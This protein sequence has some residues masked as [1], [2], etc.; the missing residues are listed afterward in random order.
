MIIERVELRHV[1]PFT[2]TVVIGP[3]GPGLNVLSANNEAGKSTI[4]KAATRALFDRHICKSEEIKGLQ[5][6]GS[7]L[8]PAITV[9][10][11]HSGQRYRVEKV[12]L[13]SPRSQVSQ[14][15]GT[16][17]Q[18]KAEGDGA[19]TLLQQILPIWSF[20]PPARTA[21]I[22]PAAEPPNRNT[23]GCSS[24]SGLGR[25]NPPLGRTGRGK[26]G[27]WFTHG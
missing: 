19:D 1:G 21:L 27:S 26:L 13:E 9:D 7:S 23:G 12:F 20:S 25:A 10:F 18:L 5:P 8:A 15:N 16:G 3:L 17:W 14:W 22:R 4:V 11:G 24:T 2:D 6:L